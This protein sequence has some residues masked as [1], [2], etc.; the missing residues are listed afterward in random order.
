MTTLT[1]QASDQQP[2]AL[3]AP[4]VLWNSGDEGDE[5]GFFSHRF[6]MAGSWR[7]TGP[8]DTAGLQW[9]LDRLVVRHTI[10]RTVVKRDKDSPTQEVVPARPVPLLVDHL[11]VAAGPDRDAA[12]ERLRNEAETGSLDPR[13]VPLLRARLVRFDAEDAVLSLVTH[14]TAGDEWS[15]QVL[16]RDLA[17]L[18][19]A[20]AE[21]RPAALPEAVQY[22]DFTHDEHAR[23]NAP[24]TE[25]DRAYWRTRLA[26]ARVFAVPTDRE[27]PHV[28]S[29]PYSAHNFLLDAATVTAARELA[30][31]A[32][33]PVSTVY[34]AA[35]NLLAHRIDG[36]TDPVIDT[37]TTV[38]PDPRHQGIVGPL[39]DFL[40][41]RTGLA[42]CDTFRD[43][44][45]A[46]ARTCREGH[47]N[48]VPIQHVED[49]LPELMSPND[50]PR[51]TNLIF[52]AFAP[53]FEPD[54]T[55][56]ADGTEEVPK[57][58]GLTPEGAW[59]P[60][61][62]AWTVHA[63]ATGELGGHIQFNTEELDPE[64]VAGW[65]RTYAALLEAAV[66][67]PDRAWNSIG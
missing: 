7:I 58:A 46:T 48:A 36:T 56:I 12:A 13:T 19:H 54:A 20:H 1:Q 43:V 22:T 66:R 5:A 30:A 62:V 53:P 15:M 38:R 40:A 45:A 11:A 33:T 28:H 17:E 23:E 4:Q 41:L 52:G 8:L 2:E 29:A 27:V 49:M 39:M 10:L 65:A 26:G 37:L 59:I 32:D 57:P 14:H 55:R 47:A 24:R 60:H 63:L 21:D 18:I 16:L 25:E 51:K 64:T 9:A 61:G 42:G 35:F 67:E 44:L 31:Q 34:L 3:S 50:E 6:T